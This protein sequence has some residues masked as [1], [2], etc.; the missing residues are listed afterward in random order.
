MWYCRTVSHGRTPYLQLHRRALRSSDLIIHT[1]TNTTLLLLDSSSLN[2]YRDYRPRLFRHQDS[3][4]GTIREFEVEQGSEYNEDYLGNLRQ[5]IA[6]LTSNTINQYYYFSQVL[7]VFVLFLFKLLG[8]KE[9]QESG[10]HT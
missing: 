9:T 1:S 6:V 4:W 10:I 5:R 3:S 7:F 8:A 2:R